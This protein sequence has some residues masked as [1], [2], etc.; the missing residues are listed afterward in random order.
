[1][2]EGVGK[3]AARASRRAVNTVAVLVHF[4]VLLHER[5][6]QTSLGFGQSRTRRKKVEKGEVDV[7]SIAFL[8]VNLNEPK[9]VTQP[10][11]KAR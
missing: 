2:T 8:E 6:N 7:C 3:G 9:P 5:S 11:R 1:M 10:P 4:Q